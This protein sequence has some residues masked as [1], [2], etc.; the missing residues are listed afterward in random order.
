MGEKVKLKKKKLFFFFF[1]VGGGE[2]GFLRFGVRL[3]TPYPSSYHSYVFGGVYSNYAPIASLLVKSCH[4][5]VLVLL[6]ILKAPCDGSANTCTGNYYARN[7]NGQEQHAQVSVCSVYR[8][9]HLK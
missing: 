4:W 5:S 6:F 7:T 9:S 3:N 1:L 2:E 8:L